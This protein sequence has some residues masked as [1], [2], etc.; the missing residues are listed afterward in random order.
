MNIGVTALGLWLGSVIP[1]RD[2]AEQERISAF[3]RAL[4]TPVGPSEVRGTSGGSARPALGAATIVVGALLI[5]AGLVSG[6][7]R[8][9]W[10]DFGLGTALAVFG[11]RFVMVKK[12][13]LQRE[14]STTL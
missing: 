3:F 12:E 13:A 2:A 9:R 1:A 14:Y 10:I 4:D 6:S 8:A 5:T 11:L 7:A